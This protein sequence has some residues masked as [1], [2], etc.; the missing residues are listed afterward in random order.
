MPIRRI[1]CGPLTAGAEQS[2]QIGLTPAAGFPF[3]RDRQRKT[4]HERGRSCVSVVLGQLGDWGIGEP[5][6]SP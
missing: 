5:S 3:K 2:G 6:C 1:L 4:P